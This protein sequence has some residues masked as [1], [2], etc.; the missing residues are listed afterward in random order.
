VKTVAVKESLCE[1]G[2][3]C[4]A[5]RVTGARIRRAAGTVAGSAPVTKPWPCGPDVTLEMSFN[6][7]PYAATLRREYAADTD[8]AGDLVL[9]G[10]SVTAVWAEYWQRKLRCRRLLERH[11]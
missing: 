8:E 10:R 7:G 1:S 4:C 6:P 3:R 11:A 9:H 5:L 2:A